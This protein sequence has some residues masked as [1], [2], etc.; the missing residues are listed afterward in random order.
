MSAHLLTWLTFLPLGGIALIVAA[1][2]LLPAHR[3]GSAR[4]IAG[5]FTTVPLVLALRMWS[6]FQPHGGVQFVDRAVWLR[7]FNIEYFLGVDGLSISMVLLTTFI[8]WLACIASNRVTT[9]PA[10]YYSLLL[11]LET[12]MLGTFCALD[13]FLFYVFWELMLLPMYFLI[14]MWG[15]PRRDYAAIKFFLYTL[16]GSVLLLLAI[17]ALYYVSAPT[18]HV[19][20][21]LAD[22]TPA[23]H[24]FNLLT[25]AQLG[26]DGMFAASAPIFGVSFTHL[27]FVALFIA[28]AIKIP[29][30]PFHTWLPDAHVEA[31]TPVSMILAGVLLKTG[32]YGLLRFNWAILPEA[33][34]WAAYAIGIFGVIN[35]VYAAFVCLAQQDF[36]K[37]IAYS[38]VSHMG[39]VLLGIAAAT[40]QAV[41]GAVF[42]MWAHG[43]V[44]PLLFALVG[45][46]YERTHS[47]KID[48][49][50]GLSHVMPEY[51][52]LT[53][54]AF[55]ASLGLPGLIGFV[56]E[57]LVML[58]SWGVARGDGATMRFQ[59]LVALAALSLVVTAAYYLWTLQRLFFG[60]TP[61]RWRDLPGALSRTERL[62]IY[63]L[64]ALTILC[65]VFPGSILRVIN[66]TLFRLAEQLRTSVGL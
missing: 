29:M 60:P 61:A 15:G 44:S 52:R 13:M 21:A 58:G 63:P 7:E 34:A 51:G 59:P 33:T 16:A 19:P 39:F 1:Q 38:S 17:I 24:T 43:I 66:P 36:K 40:P 32:A 53:G 9:R 35:I 28:F 12:G 5:V 8:T 54:L 62:T 65:G 50:G 25:L 11:L 18:A 27:V 10:G 31:P 41:S 26:Q 57:V 22:G 30:V 47:R 37:L 3:T 55:F 64:A 42:Q 45:V 56:G 14:G 49:F 48:D 20:F 6:E 46:L 2:A 23:T 4:A